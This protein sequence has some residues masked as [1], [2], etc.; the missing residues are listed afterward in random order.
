MSCRS[1]E[2]LFLLVEGTRGQTLQLAE[3]AHGELK[4]PACPARRGMAWLACLAD[5]AAP[6]A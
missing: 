4:E 5:G 3:G 1:R 6:V 2:A